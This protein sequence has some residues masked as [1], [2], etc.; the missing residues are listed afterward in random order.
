M[1]CDAIK[2]N[3]FEAKFK[4]VI[5]S[6]FFLIEVLIWRCILL[7]TAPE[8]DQWFQSYKLLKDSQNRKQK[9]IPVSDYI[10]QSLLPT[11][12]WFP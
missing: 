1:V 7:K 3:Q 9:F 12:D 5:L 6:L 4:H 11:S 2:G 10:S 8:S